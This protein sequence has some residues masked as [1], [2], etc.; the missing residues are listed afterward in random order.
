MKSIWNGDL[1]LFVLVL[2]FWSELQ[3]SMTLSCH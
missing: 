1:S 2:S 3:V